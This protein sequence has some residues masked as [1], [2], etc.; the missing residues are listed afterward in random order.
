MGVVVLLATLND[1]LSL[2]KGLVSSLEADSLPGKDAALLAGVFS[3]LEHA[4]A[5]GKAICAGRVEEVG[6]ATTEGHKDTASW[7]AGLSGDS[8]GAAKEVL[9]TAGGLAELPGLLG[10][11]SAGELSLKEASQI[12]RAGALDPSSEKELLE[13][14]REG[15][16]TKLRERTEAV[17]AAA[18]S[19]EEEH[20]REERVRKNRHFSSWR[21][22][23][24]A[25]SGRFSLE[26]RDGA[27]LLGRLEKIADTL[28]EEARRQ[29]RQEPRAAYLA[30]ALVA[31]AKGEDEAV[32]TRESPLQGG[33]TA[34]AS[35]AGAK[36]P[37]RSYRPDYTI[38]MRVDL[39]ALLRGHVEKGEECS[40]D[41]VGHVSVAVVQEYLEQAKLRLVVT[42]GTDISSIYSF[43][44]V[45]PALLRTAL[46]FRDRTC[47]VPGCTSTFHLEI[48]H[49]TE[50][51]NS[52]PTSLENTC[53]LCRYH[54]SLKTNRGY[55]IEG[56]PG[57]WKWVRPSG[58]DQPE[59]ST[60]PGYS[61]EAREAPLR[62]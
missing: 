59:E 31:L 23:E 13:V 35:T 50:Y 5:A 12:A 48:D 2:I 55:K 43:S 45:I 36:A 1:H 4:C 39:E 62:F 22:K 11:F 6:Y 61:F 15:S 54:H 10:A 34:A 37:R 38:L 26:P 3:S 17:C 16:L 47:V 28:F 51:A 29:K 53:R 44:R 20:E 24:G 33:G 9:E 46:Q 27:V 14:A 52:G 40:I 7:L 56:G 57:S 21:D 41:G 18:R 30:D 58:L 19:K 25:F 42:K 49:I 32:L 8:H 60:E